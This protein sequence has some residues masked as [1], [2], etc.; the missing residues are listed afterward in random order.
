MIDG[1]KKSQ[2]DYFEEID[3]S[4][5]ASIRDLCG[6]KLTMDGRLQHWKGCLVLLVVMS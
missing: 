5:A 4:G 1:E 2:D 6:G 3:N